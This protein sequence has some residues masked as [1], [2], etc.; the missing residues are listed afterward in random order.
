MEVKGSWGLRLTISPPSVSRFST[1]C[2]SLYVSQP[3][4]PS[5]PATGIAFYHVKV[6][7][8]F[9]MFGIGRIM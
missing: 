7:T 5:W 3:Y 2:G 1:K 9:N 8:R 6:Y 4:G